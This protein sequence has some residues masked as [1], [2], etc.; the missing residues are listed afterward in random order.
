MINRVLFWSIFFFIIGFSPVF[1]NEN[2]V[3][4]PEEN[5]DL[6]F[7]EAEDAV[8]TNFN[9]EPTLNYGS[10]G[11]RTLQLSRFNPLPGGAPFFAEYVLFVEDPGTYELWYG[12]TPPGSKDDFSPSY[13]SPFSFSLD[14]KET[15]N[16]YMEDV[17]IA[18]E[19]LPSFYWCKT[20]TYTLTR[21]IHIFRFEVNEKR[22][23]DGKFL[24]FLDA[25]F[26]VN[27]EKKAALDVSSL[28]M[29]FPEKI[30]GPLESLE[31][32]DPAVYENMLKDNPD[33]EIYLEL[34]R[35]YSLIGDY[36]NALRALKKAAQLEPEN[37]EIILLT[38]KNR[39]WK[40]DV[41]EGLSEYWKLLELYPEKQ[42]IWAEAG[43]VAAW[44]GKYDESIRFFQSGIQGFPDDLNLY[45][46]LA[47]TY[48]WAS[49]NKEAEEY[50]QKA[51]DLAE[52]DAGLVK[53][54]GRILTVN[55]YPEKAVEVYSR[56]LENFPENLE[57]YL[58]L[59][60]AYANIGLQEESENVFSLLEQNLP[61]SDRLSTYIE[62][63]RKKQGLKQ[64]LIEQYEEELEL[65]PDNVELRQQLVQTY[66]WNGM[67][68]KAI[69][70]YLN[71]ITN[72]GFS[73]LLAMEKKSFDLLSIIDRLYLYKQRFKNLP[74]ELSAN[75][76][77][78]SG[79]I[80]AVN[81]AQTAYDKAAAKIETAREKGES[82]EGLSSAEEESALTAAQDALAGET[83][84]QQDFLFDIENLAESYSG[85]LDEIE[86]AAAAEKEESGKFKKI[87]DPIFW[88]WDKNGYIEE[89]KQISQRENALADYLLTKIYLYD[90]NLKDADIYLKKAEG[91]LETPS[92]L[93]LSFQTQLW[94]SSLPLQRED[95]YT[96]PL[97]LQ[98]YIPYSGELQDLFPLPASETSTFFTDAIAEESLD[99]ISAYDDIRKNIPKIVKEIDRGLSICHSIL[100]KRLTRSMFA[101]QEDTYLIRF[102]LGDYYLTENDLP[103]ATSQF[104]QVLAIDPWNTSALYKIGVVRQRYGDWKEAMRFYR[105][106]YSQ[107]PGFENAAEYNNQLARAHADSVDFSAYTLADTSSV[108][109]HGEASFLSNITSF[110]GLKAIY[111]GDSKKTY[112]TFGDEIPSMY[113]VHSVSAALPFSLFQNRLK[114]LPGIGGSFFSRIYENSFYLEGERIFSLPE[115]LE[116]Y[117]VYPFTEASITASFDPV[118]GSARYRFGRYSESYNPE[119]DIV[120][121]HLG[122]ASAQFSFGF[123]DI[124]VIKGT[125]L[126][127]YGKLN[128]L[129][130][131]KE[132]E[133]DKK[134][135][136][137]GTIAQ[138]LTVNIHLLDKPWTTL[139]VDGDF[140]YENSKKKEEQNYYTPRGVIS[141]KGGLG[142][143]AWISLPGESVLGLYLKGAGGIYLENAGTDDVEKNPQVEGLTRIDLQKGDSS[144]YFSFQGTATF[145][146]FPGTKYWSLYATIGYSAK[147][148]RLLAE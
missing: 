135:N 95:A 19:Y 57:I 27:A 130:T 37:P 141:G 26:F 143:S 51:E 28:P 109:F 140:V 104:R 8:S 97:E 41:N 36:I 53:D 76:T 120:N 81:D 119:K 55:G 30:E 122:E 126:R 72:I 118:Y 4:F 128:F 1:S 65:Q 132:T 5:K 144:Y 121:S 59:S 66:F 60:E 21:G 142:G 62:T 44:T 100:E 67:R 31:F 7:I 91:S 108:T 147:L 102:E 46:N 32:K 69:Q 38:A 110:F 34:S 129:K 52:D 58:L 73:E 18:E 80:K 127:T 71:I 48:L 112:K 123:L 107:D 16:F 64:D 96:L 79:M 87:T 13:A 56:A 12:G 106:V 24:F 145:D 85:V 40:G 117:E 93:L 78:L 103:A 3:I 90:R 43:K 116:T 74:E 14:G 10:S 49:K 124:P 75:K 47:L 138:N 92:L 125:S 115:F 82:L 84:R 139:I 35:I 101:F 86:P 15:Q 25:F 70:E 6:I 133:P 98:E 50:F 146:D 17:V 54:L 63:F 83:I 9:K 29:V 11:F 68:G 111:E 45:V 88:K 77:L 2:T 113:Q 89:L 136:F 137:I 61:P 42:N 148:P 39:I 22:R 33:A 23:Y 94:D 131:V 105:K 20:G 134:W 114:V 99:V